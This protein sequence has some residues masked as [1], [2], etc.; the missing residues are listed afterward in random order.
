MRMTA[1]NVLADD[2]TFSGIVGFDRMFARSP[3]GLFDLLSNDETAQLAAI[4]K[5]F[6]G[7]GVRDLRLFFGSR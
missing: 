1:S 5:D 7:N 2:A 6:A 3:M 4:Y